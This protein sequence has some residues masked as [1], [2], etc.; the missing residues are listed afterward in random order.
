MPNT[1]MKNLD[2][3]LRAAASI[4][5]AE[6]GRHKKCLNATEILAIAILMRRPVTELL[7]PR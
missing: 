2:C 3:N 4:G 1:L 5:V 6:I 7:A